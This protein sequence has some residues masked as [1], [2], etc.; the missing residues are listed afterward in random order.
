MVTSVVETC[1]YK[2]LLYICWYDQHVELWNVFSNVKFLPS[3]RQA[4][5]PV[6]N[7]QSKLRTAP[8][9]CQNFSLTVLCGSNSN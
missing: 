4:G 7:V 5:A 6:K 2:Q 1:E 3:H 8:D 9:L